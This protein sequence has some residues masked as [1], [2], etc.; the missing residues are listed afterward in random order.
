MHLLNGPQQGTG[1]DRTFRTHIASGDGKI[2]W[3]FLAAAWLTAIG[4]GLYALQRYE[5]DPSPAARPASCWPQTTALAKPATGYH[6]VLFAHPRCPCTRAT[7]AELAR[8]MAHCQGALTATVL[9]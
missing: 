8:L 4:A 9:F 1:S 2:L 6:L 5:V 3:I 7:V